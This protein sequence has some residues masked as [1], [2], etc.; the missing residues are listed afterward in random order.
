MLRAAATL[1]EIVPDPPDAVIAVQGGI[2]PDA[3][4]AEL[5]VRGAGTGF[6]HRHLGTQI[7]G[8]VAELTQVLIER[9]GNRRQHRDGD[10]RAGQLITVPDDRAHPT[11]SRGFCIAAQRGPRIR[12]PR[13]LTTLLV[14]QQT[15]VPP[16][17]LHRTP[18]Q[19]CRREPR[20]HNGRH[21][22]RSTEHQPR[23]IRRPAAVGQRV[24][25]LQDGHSSRFG[26]AG[27]ATDPGE[28]VKAPGGPSR[29]EL[30]V[31]Q[32]PHRGLAVVPVRFAEIVYDEL[33]VADIA[34]YPHRIPQPMIIA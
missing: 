26:G 18:R 1:G 34:G 28:D 31:G 7:R 32:P 27:N 22:P 15:T 6:G 13:N 4:I 14:P 20:H 23:Q 9:M 19:P 11:R 8:V 30:V 2:E 29:V 17:G 21:A 12:L 3:D 33:V 24:R 5:V 16:G 25:H 10:R